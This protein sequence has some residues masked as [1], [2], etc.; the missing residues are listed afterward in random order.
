MP[1][2]DSG[3]WLWEDWLSRQDALTS[4][5]RPKSVDELV[6]FLGSFSVDKLRVR[7]IGAG[8]S[9]STVARPFRLADD[10][11]RAGVVVRADAMA[12]SFPDAAKSW[13]KPGVVASEKLARVEAG[14]TIAALNRRFFDQG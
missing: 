7:G 5:L 13:W 11:K 1:Q 6:A 8:H 12:L 10:K 2:L 14:A 3:P 9:T 4:Y